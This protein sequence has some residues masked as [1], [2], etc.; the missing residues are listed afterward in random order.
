M[1]SAQFQSTISQSSTEADLIAAVKARKLA[2]YLHS[3][4]NDL[5]IKQGDVTPLYEDNAAA[6]SIAKLI[7]PTF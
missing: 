5:G 4:L 2:L 6:I 7:Q 3:I 1:Y